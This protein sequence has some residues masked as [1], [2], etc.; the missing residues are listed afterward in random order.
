MAEIGMTSE[1]RRM[2]RFNK[3]SAKKSKCIARLMR[4][5]R[6]IVRKLD[7]KRRWTTTI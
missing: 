2:F 1:T 6:R 7:M 5:K 4:R 3:I